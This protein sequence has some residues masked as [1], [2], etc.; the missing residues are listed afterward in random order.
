M[1]GAADLYVEGRI[2]CCAEDESGSEEDEDGSDDGESDSGDSESGSEYDSEA[3]HKIAEEGGPTQQSRPAPEERR[4]ALKGHGVSIPDAATN[5]HIADDLAASDEDSSASEGPAEEDMGASAGSSE[6]D[7]SNAEAEVEE[8]AAAAAASAVRSK[9]A[10]AAPA[11]DD[12]APKAKKPRS[13]GEPGSSY[14][15]LRLTLQ[16]QQEDLCV[17]VRQKCCAWEFAATGPQHP[18]PSPVW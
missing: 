8:A 1:G 5:G 4:K 7:D 2:G 3:A 11:A 9:A 6:E 18:M 16:V 13:A 15:M 10:A 14:R 17:C 12:D